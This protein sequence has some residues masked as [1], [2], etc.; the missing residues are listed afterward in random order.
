MSKTTRGTF[1]AVLGFLV[2]GVLPLAAQAAKGKQNLYDKF[3]LNLSVTGVILNS[4]IR[5]DG[6]GGNGTDV[7]VED[8]LGMEKTKIQPRFSLR[9]R[10]GRRHELEGGYQWARRSA[11]KTLSR[12]IEFAD[13]SFTAGADIHS[14]FNTDLAFLTYRFAFMAKERTQIGAALGLGILFLDVGVEA[15]GT[16]TGPG[17]GR[18]FDV[19]KSV[20]G[21]LGSLGLYGR[22]LAGDSWQFEADIRA[23]KI[24]IDRF[25]PRVLEAG[26]AARYYF[27]PKV[28]LELGYAAS[29]IRV[30]VDPKTF[31]NG[32]EG[33][34]SG[35]IK[36]SLQS[37][38]FG[39]V[40][41]P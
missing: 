14:I 8:D 9:W 3:Q 16:G 27:S 18:S 30:V 31:E 41:V 25:H 20:K 24:S 4:D 38:R 1:L 21:P 37:I 15:L 5:I 32:S 12:D 22:F 39:A 35:E 36:Y 19:S 7:D 10:P 2:A 26:G 13:S 28:G 40:F 34:V 6:S 11:D 17:A 29:G 23:L 33:I